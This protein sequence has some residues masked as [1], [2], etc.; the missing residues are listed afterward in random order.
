MFFSLCLWPTFMVTV[1]E[2]DVR[3]K[4]KPQNVKHILLKIF[5]LKGVVLLKPKN[6]FASDCK[7]LFQKY[8]SWT[9]PKTHHI[10]SHCGFLSAVLLC[11]V[12]VSCMF[13]ISQLNFHPNTSTDFNWDLVVADVFCVDCAVNK[14]FNLGSL[15]TVRVVRGLWMDQVF[16]SENVI[17]RRPVPRKYFFLF[18]L[19]EDFPTRLHLFSFF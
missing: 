16:L 10:S 18:S 6:L 11:R 4:G 14:E 19:E 8:S 1:S 5:S 17:Y 3:H 2:N 7:S 15:Q 9:R 13:I 12:A